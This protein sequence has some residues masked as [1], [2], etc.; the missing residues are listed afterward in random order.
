MNTAEPTNPFNMKDCF[1]QEESFLEV[2]RSVLYEL[3]TQL[4]SKTFMFM[5]HAFSL[6]VPKRQYSLCY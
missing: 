4:V 1:L 2:F 5:K 6:F 3:G